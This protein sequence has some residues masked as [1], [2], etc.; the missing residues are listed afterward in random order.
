MCHPAVTQDALFFEHK[1][2]EMQKFLQTSPT[3]ISINLF[4]PHITQ[5]T[6][7]N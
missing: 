2:E 6:I 7:Y 5:T 4:F 3:Q 1:I